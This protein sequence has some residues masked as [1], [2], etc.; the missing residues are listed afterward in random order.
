VF[1]IEAEC[2]QK[3][4]GVL[5]VLQKLNLRVASGEVYGLLGPNGAGKST[6]I[7]LLLGLLRPDAG[8][9]T[10]LGLLPSTACRRVGYLPERVRYHT[11]CTAREYLHDLGVFSNLRGPAL[12][13]RCRMLL[14]QTGLAAAADRRLGTYSKGMLQRLGVAQALLHSPELLLIDEPTSGLDPAGQHE[15]LELLAELRGQGRTILLCTHQLAEV[16]ALC[17]RVGI[18]HDGRLAAEARVRD[19]AAPGGITI[20]IKGGALPADLVGTLRTLGA[21]VAGDELHLGADDALQAHV[22]RLVLDA[23]LGIAELRPAGSALI[24]LYLRV[25]HGQP[26][27]ASAAPA[28][29]KEPT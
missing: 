23:G 17:D 16:E 22:L 7:H 13:E 4:Y 9:L 10:V 6:L 5:Q 2:L 14:Q 25:M 3:R 15:L 26:L 1:A 12:A 11:H 24:D 18:L 21:D 8:Q 19:L 29:S 20:T 28:P 27:P